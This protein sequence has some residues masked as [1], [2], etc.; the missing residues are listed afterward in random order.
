MKIHS[1]QAPSFDQ[2]GSNHFLVHNVLCTKTPLS[3]HSPIIPHFALNP[4][5]YY[6]N[7]IGR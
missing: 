7:C 1:I 5:Y 6:A 4:F 3:A 2:N